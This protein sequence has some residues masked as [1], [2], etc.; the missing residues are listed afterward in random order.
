[1]ATTVFDENRIP[2]LTATSE[3]DG[4]TPIRIKADA[5]THGLMVDD[6][7]TGSDLSGDN[8]ARDANRRTVLM[9]VS[10]TDGVTPVSVYVTADGALLIDST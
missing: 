2:A 6:G 1:M 10:E 3:D 4:S 5:T 9:A 7:T 8:A